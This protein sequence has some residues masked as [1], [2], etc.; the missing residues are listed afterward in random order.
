[1]PFEEYFSIR[2]VEQRTGVKP[3]TLR[4]WQ[5]RYGLVNPHR[6]EKGHRLY[7]EQD[8]Q[9]I[10]QILHWLA[11]G[12]AI[13][14]VK[15]L[16]DS[17]Q[18]QLSPPLAAEH[19]DAQTCR[20]IVELLANGSTF[21]VRERLKECYELYPFDV[22]EQRVVTPVTQM[23][24]SSEQPL[25]SVQRAIWRYEL[26]LQYQFLITASSQSAV[27]VALLINLD[28]QGDI[29]AWQ[30]AARLTSLGYKVNLLDGLGVI[31]RTTFRWLHSQP[32]DCLAIYGSRKLEPESYSNLMALSQTDERETLVF[33]EV[34]QIHFAQWR[35]AG[36]VA[37][38]GNTE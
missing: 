21:K 7:T 12:V 1:M 28:A 38:S 8:I 37:F 11:R 3:V 14:K 13:G 5:R 30:T 10:E 36:A 15:A 20:E 31:D 9:H 32:G 34:A 24:S 18:E 35:D 27:R 4:A 19:G 23:L 33:G 26:M 16:L 6:S 25:A 2:E 17:A 29:G 22:A